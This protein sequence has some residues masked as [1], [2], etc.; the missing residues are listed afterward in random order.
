MKNAISQDL[1][2]HLSRASF[3]P[4]PHPLGVLESSRWPSYPQCDSG[5]FS[6]MLP[7]SHQS[8]SS[9]PARAWPRAWGQG[10]KG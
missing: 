4:F 3:E 5:L 10:P 9:I 6:E 7:E 2:P 8:S 1:L